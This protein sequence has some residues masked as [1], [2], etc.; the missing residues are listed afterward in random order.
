MDQCAQNPIT[1]PT[2]EKIAQYKVSQNV[3]RYSFGEGY[4][5]DST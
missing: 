1:F 5:G 3:L 2:S 4:D